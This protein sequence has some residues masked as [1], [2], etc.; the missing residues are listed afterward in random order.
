MLLQSLYTIAVMALLAGALLTSALVSAK[1]AIHE[2]AT[3]HVATALARG[4]NDFSTWAANYVYQHRADAQWPM[5]PQ[6][7]A[8][9]PVCGGPAAQASCNLF[10]TTTYQVTGSTSASAA[11]ANGASTGNATAQN[12]QTLVDEQRISADITATI[13]NASGNVI[14]TG[15]R[16]VTARV[17]DAPPYAIVTGTRDVSS[18]LGS[19][20]AA[21]GDT[22]GALAPASDVEEKTSPD[23]LNPMLYQDTVIN[24]TMTCSN[25][26]AN[27]NQYNP[28]LD[29]NP[30]GNNLM[31]WG[32][33]AAGRAYEA[34]CEP[35]YDV[36]GAPS[37]A[38]DAVN[39]N[40]KVGLFASPESWSNES[41]TA[42]SAW[43]Q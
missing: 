42:Q 23:P 20:H 14:G 18:V 8:P 15:T 10:V 35:K 5:Q 38:D 7:T 28:G 16:E 22:G 17:F 13:T 37:D 24:V 3:R 25:S 41:S 12:L 32:V 31:S 26:A 19:V 4:T 33:Q 29:N 36:S 34:P 40:Y 11:N 39:G 30:P 27:D 1:A 21:E 43:T 6:S 2:A 9:E